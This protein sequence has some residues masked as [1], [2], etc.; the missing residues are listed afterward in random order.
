MKKLGEMFQKIRNIL[1][2]KG[3]VIKSMI[4][5]NNFIKVIRQD[6]CV[7]YYTIDSKQHTCWAQSIVVENRIVKLSSNDI[8][9]CYYTLDLKICI[10][11]EKCES[12]LNKKEQKINIESLLFSLIEKAEV[13]SQPTSYTL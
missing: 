6:R 13:T 8:Y 4:L 10:E 5:E 1:G 11:L 2:E 7:C 3:V 9:I 12:D